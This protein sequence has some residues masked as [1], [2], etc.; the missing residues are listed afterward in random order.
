[1]DLPGAVLDVGRGRADLVLDC[2]RG[3]GGA[4]P[5]QFFE[6]LGDLPGGELEAIR[7]WRPGQ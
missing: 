6:V 2:G 1:V 7:E 5:S 3:V 4:G